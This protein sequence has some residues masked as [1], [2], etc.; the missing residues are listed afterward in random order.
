MYKWKA[1][2]YDLRYVDDTALFSENEEVLEK[3]PSEQPPNLQ[4]E[5]KRFWYADEN[6]HN[7]HILN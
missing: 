7:E 1:K 2:S 4:E 5:D 6:Q 3:A